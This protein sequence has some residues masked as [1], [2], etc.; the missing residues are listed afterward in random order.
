MA[1]YIAK[2]S[3]ELIR[4][5]AQE[6]LRNFAT[7]EKIA[8]NHNTSPGTISNILFKGVAENILD[9]ITAEA[10]ANKAMNNT[11]NV[12]RTRKRWEK[13]LKLREL[14]VLEAEVQAMNNKLEQLK[15]QFENYDDYFIDEDEAPSKRRLKCDIGRLT[16]EIRNLENY[17][18]KLRGY[19]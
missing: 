7:M 15:F 3:N 2:V 13:A 18:T 9:D 17:M 10:V 16:G 1:L 6:Y 14:P 12:V 8:K 5:I 11:D 19:L 4:R